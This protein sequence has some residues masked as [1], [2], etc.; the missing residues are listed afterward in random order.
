MLKQSRE[1]HCSCGQVLPVVSTLKHTLQV[2][3]GFSATWLF[4]TLQKDPGLS[5]FKGTDTSGEKL[6]CMGGRIKP[7]PH[8][9]GTIL[10]HVYMVPHRD[11]SPIAYSNN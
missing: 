1:F 6:E 11:W 2:V 4:P 7:Q 3:L 10:R 5:Y 8:Y 9:G